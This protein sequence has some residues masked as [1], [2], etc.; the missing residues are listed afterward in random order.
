MQLKCPECGSTKTREALSWR[1]ETCTACSR[2]GHEVYMESAGRRESGLP[3]PS[4]LAP[5]V[6]RFLEPPRTSN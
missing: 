6:Q 5:V 3:S 1:L 4:D 2:D